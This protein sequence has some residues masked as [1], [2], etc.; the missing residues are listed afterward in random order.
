MNSDA[1]HLFMSLLAICMSSLEKRLWRASAHF[2]N[3]V[4]CFFYFYLFIFKLKKIFFFFRSAPCNMWGSSSPA[5]E[6]N[7]YPLQ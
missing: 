2:F 5:R 1:K 6:S 7:L 4:V 3:Q